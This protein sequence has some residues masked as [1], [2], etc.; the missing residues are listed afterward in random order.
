[1]LERRSSYYYIIGENTINY[2]LPPP[3]YIIVYVVSTV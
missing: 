1:M 3:V 2:S